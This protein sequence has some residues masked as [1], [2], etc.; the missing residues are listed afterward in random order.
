MVVEPNGDILLSH[1]GNLWT[2]PGLT[3][4]YA[5]PNQ[6]RVQF[7][8]AEI[9]VNEL[10]GIATVTIQRLGDSSNALTVDYATRGGTARAGLSY[11]ATRGTLA[12]AP[13][14]VIKTI[15]IPILD[16]RVFNNNLT[17]RVTLSRPTGGL[18]G[19][20]PL[21]VTIRD[22]GPRILSSGPGFGFNGGQ[23]GFVLTGPGGQSVVVEASDDLADW[24]PVWT[25]TFTG[26]LQFTDPQSGAA[27]QRFY[28]TRAP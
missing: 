10:S 20:N 24:L 19:L 6:P 12:F 1:G 21:T 22:R 26:A 14:E 25:N 27:P 11:V 18:L 9:I 3:R 28:R 17:V 4:F 7:D 16:D 5:N 15:S 13:L 23:F 2:P 8:S